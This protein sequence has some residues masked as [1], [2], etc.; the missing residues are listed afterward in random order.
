MDG[1]YVHEGGRRGGFRRLME[2]SIL[3]FHFVFRITSLTN[4]LQSAGG[5]NYAT[6]FDYVIPDI[7]LNV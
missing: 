6:N 4:S 7:G 5:G 1:F 2:N 3:N